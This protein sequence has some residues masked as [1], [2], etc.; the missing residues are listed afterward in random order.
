MES[1]EDALGG[2][3]LPDEDNDSPFDPMMAQAIEE[4]SQWIGKGVEGVGEGRT[5]DGDPCVV[6]FV[7]RGGVQLE[8]RLPDAIRGFAV[9][10]SGTDE[11]HA[12]LS[13]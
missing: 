3:E 2:V 1:R 8:D 5:E 7:S 6:V 13:D 9:I 4:A 10:V 11:F 12:L